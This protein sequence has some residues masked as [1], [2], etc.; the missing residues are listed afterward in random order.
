M[1]YLFAQLL[2]YAASTPDANGTIDLIQFGFMGIAVL[3]FSLGKVHPDSTVKSREQDFRD[4]IALLE[5]KL[6]SEAT[7][8]KAV[9]DAVIKDV[10]PVMARLV[11]RDKEMVGLV[12]QL[13]AWATAQDGNK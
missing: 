4:R 5:K 9:R 13:L 10:A 8:S 12:A 11:D 7:D 2:H 3:W 1:S 6:E